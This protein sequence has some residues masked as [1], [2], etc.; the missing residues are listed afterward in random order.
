MMPAL[1]AGT[2][3]CVLPKFFLREA[4]DSNLLERLLP[5]WSIPHWAPFTG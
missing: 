4:L 5:D 2:G 1:I 3:L